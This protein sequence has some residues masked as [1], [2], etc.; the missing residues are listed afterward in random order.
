MKDQG[1]ASWKIKRGPNGV[2]AI[3][4]FS[5]GAPGPAM[6]GAAGATERQA[7]ARATVIAKQIAES[8]IFQA[9]APPGTAAALKAINAIATSKDIQATLAKYSGPGARRLARAIRRLW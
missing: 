3:V 6:V 8:P 4:R 5:A 9:V 1:L 2:V 7:L